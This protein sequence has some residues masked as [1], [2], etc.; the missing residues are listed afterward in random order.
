MTESKYIKP[1]MKPKIEKIKK[2][3][4][5][6]IIDLISDEPKLELINKYYNQFN[7]PGVNKLFD[8]IESK[9]DQKNIP[10]RD[11]VNT[12]YKTKNAEQLLKQQVVK[13]DFQLGHLVAL[14][15]FQTIQMDIV[16]MPQFQ[17]QN[18]NYKYF[19]LVIDIFTRKA[20][21]KKLKTKTTTEVIDKFLEIIN[22]MGD[23]PKIIMSDND[24][25]FLSN[26]FQSICN[27]N[28][29]ILHVNVVGDHAFL[30]V[31]DNFCKR[32]KLIFAKIFI[33]NNSTNWIDHIQ[34]VLDKYNDTPHSS[35][36]TL[37]P[38]ESLLK[39]NFNNILDINLIKS[40][41]NKT[42][43][44][45]QIGDYVRL[46]KHGKFKKSSETQWSDNF[47]TVTNIDANNITIDNGPIVRRNNL[48]VVYNYK[49]STQDKKAHNN[50]IKEAL[51]D[52][53]I[54]RKLKHEGIEKNEDVSNLIDSIKSRSRK[55]IDRK[56]FI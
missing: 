25:T 55:K 30:G 41:K 39:I 20:F 45:L 29:I 18:N 7:F 43:S 28:E 32:I 40:L 23:I 14:F 12:F 22:E 9:E 19:L 27:K 36:D 8:I 48:L 53:K 6:K 26:E 24:S 52:A 11:E 38:N 31:I 21:A 34:P 54:D 15:P 17:R 50:V 44:D 56:N 1:D 49:P 10:T 4:Q 46:K 5:E 13:R 35:L 33:T 37:S 47:Y 2:T 42:V 3:Q 51:E 16:F